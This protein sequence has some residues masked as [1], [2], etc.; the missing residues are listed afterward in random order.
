MR[1]HIDPVRYNLT[2]LVALFILTPVAMV[3]GALLLSRSACYYLLSLAT[4]TFTVL[5]ARR[6]KRKQTMKEKIM[7]LYAA[8]G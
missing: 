2:V 4:G 3:I 7:T 5:E 1:D 6:A 8:G